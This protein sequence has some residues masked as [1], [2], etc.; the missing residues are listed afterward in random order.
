MRLTTGHMW[1]F[2]L[3][4][5]RLD[6]KLDFKHSNSENPVTHQGPYVGIEESPLLLTGA[7]WLGLWLS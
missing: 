3:F 6:F 5:F 7:T 2:K 1:T 4:N